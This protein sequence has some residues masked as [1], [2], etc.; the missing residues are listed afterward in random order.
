MDQP[1][2]PPAVPRGPVPL[3][4][5]RPAASR[6]SADPE[7]ARTRR[8]R[9]RAA[10]ELYLHR[11]HEA[12]LFVRRRPRL[13]APM[14]PLPPPTPPGHV[15]VLPGRGEVFYRHHTGGEPGRPT[16]L[17]L[18]GW[19]ASADLQWFA[20][21]QELGERYPFI[22]VDHRGHGRGLRSDEPFSL[23][24]A[25]DDAAALVRELGVGPV[26]C[27]G[28]SMGGPVSLLTWQ[29]HPDLVQGLVLAATALEW[30]A[31]RIERLRWKVLAVSRGVLSSPRARRAVHRGLA[32]LVEGEA[33]DLAAYLPWFSAEYR[34]GD[35]DAIIDAG[36]AL[37]RYDFRPHVAAV[38]VPA[39]YVLT[40]TDTLVPPRKQRALA[41]GLRAEV[42]E[43]QGDHLA[44]FVRGPQFSAALRR[45]VDGVADR[46]DAT[47]SRSA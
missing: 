25:A 42:V 11:W 40:V 1:L 19:T 29:R 10:R 3:P 18:H 9:A 46:L 13:A 17:L 45:A 8:E 31:S 39:G 43:V 27:V 22:A 36:W 16:L 35:V 4:G 24:A 26:I 23:E 41:A 2:D 38:D 34:R 30:R 37:S 6:R 47:A 28:Y 15:R 32:T 5:H 12:K 20:C 33:S 21:Y 7:V 44:P 14:A